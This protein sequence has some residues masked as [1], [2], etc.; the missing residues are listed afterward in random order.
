VHAFR[1]V[2]ITSVVVATVMVLGGVPVHAMEPSLVHAAEPS[3]ALS[4][5]R[6]FS[7]V[8]ATSDSMIAVALAPASSE[9]FVD[10]PLGGPLPGGLTST[11]I[12]IAS[13][14]C[15]RDVVVA[16]RDGRRAKF[17]MVDVCR[18]TG[19]KVTASAA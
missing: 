18:S 9:A 4:Q 12:R 14:P 17:P 2:A 7:L 1:S 19:I 5:S 3:R 13:G 11:M 6:L 16:F 10:A 15:L 8:N